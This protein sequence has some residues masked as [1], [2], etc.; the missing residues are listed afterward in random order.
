MHAAVGDRLRCARAEALPDGRGTAAASFR[1]KASAHGAG[2]R[3]TRPYQSQ[4]SGK[5]GVS[6]RIPAGRVGVPPTLRLDEERLA[7]LLVFLREYNHARPHDGVGGAVPA[8]RL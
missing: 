1:W 6:V 3:R 4:T 2:L 8:S 7:A 5:A